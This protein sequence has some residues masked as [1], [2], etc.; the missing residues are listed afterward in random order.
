MCLTSLRCRFLAAATGTDINDIAPPQSQDFSLL[1]KNRSISEQAYLDERGP[2]VGGRLAL[3]P[4]N[5]ESN[6][7]DP[8]PTMSGMSE[9]G[10]RAKNTLLDAFQP[11]RSPPA[12]GQP[13]LRLRK[14]GLEFYAKNA[15]PSIERCATRTDA[16]PVN[17][18][19]SLRVRRGAVRLKANHRGSRLPEKEPPRRRG[20][21]RLQPRSSSRANHCPSCGGTN[22]RLLLTE[23]WRSTKPIL[24]GHSGAYPRCVAS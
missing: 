5:K 16:A 11:H 21:A 14:F 9:R 12:R 19:R 8:L 23:R 2:G 13:D 15:P 10:Y 18:A 6:P 4:S 22:H 20:D 3:L 17:R 7:P 24:K 1:I